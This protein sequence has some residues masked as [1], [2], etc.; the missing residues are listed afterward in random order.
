M[1]LSF[2][3]QLQQMNHKAREIL[4]AGAMSILRTKKSYARSAIDLCL[5]QTVNKYAASL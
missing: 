2:S 5:E 4:E 3:P 1:G